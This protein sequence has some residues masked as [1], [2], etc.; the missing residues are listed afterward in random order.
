MNDLNKLLEASSFAAK[1]HTGHTRKGST[2]EPYI[3]HPLEVASL[4]ANVGG[5]E[6]FDVLI[7][8][9]LHDTIEDVGVTKEEIAERWG[10]EVASIVAEVTDDKSLEK[11]ERKRLQIE[12]AP[13]LSKQAKLVKLAD[14][15]SNIT[16]VMNSPP[17]D[18][19]RARRLEYVKWGEAVVAG[20]RGTNE[21]LE[22]YFDEIAGRA[23]GK[24]EEA[25]N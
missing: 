3:N 25:A 10:A 13:G 18:W 11:Q 2:Q 20:L 16:D 4:L 1:K 12:H 5:I 23:K 6:D 17:V 9:L 24:F 15:I 19:D 22:K 21:P 8:A 14:K 7:A